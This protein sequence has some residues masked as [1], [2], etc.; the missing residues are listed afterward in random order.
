MNNE[1]RDLIARF[2][3]RVGGAPSGGAFGGSSQAPSLPPIDPEADRFIAE[4]FQRYPE[5]RYRVTQMAVVQEAALV[6]AQNR[7]RQLEFQLQ[8][9]QSQ[10]AQSQQQRGAS[11]GGGG[12]FGGLFGGG[13]R[14]QQAAPPPGWG[15]QQGYAAPPPPQA[16]F[17]PGYQP[18]M[19]QS[20]G[21]GFLGSALTTAAGVAGGM[22][23]ANAL[24]GLFSGHHDGLGGGFGGAGGGNET[25]INNY[26][27][28]GA[29]PFGGAGT[30]VDPGFDAGS[31]GDSGGGW[32]DDQF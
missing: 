19:F 22:L 3:A 5:A 10:L 7:I 4:N 20:R 6:E 23:T 29:D 9:A 18:G 17:P 21:S 13:N 14:Q 15:G 11:G 2:V 1:E 8:Q 28:S 32:G 30:D 12:L 31:F 16:S 26:G 24:E 27:D 25:I